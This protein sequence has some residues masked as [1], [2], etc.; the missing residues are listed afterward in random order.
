MVHEEEDAIL[1]LMRKLSSTSRILVQCKMR[2]TGLFLAF[3][4][5]PF[6][7]WSLDLSLLHSCLKYP[8][9]STRPFA[10]DIFTSRTLPDMNMLATFSSLRGTVS[11]NRIYFHFMRCRCET[12]FLLVT[13]DWA[14]FHQ[15]NCEAICLKNNLNNDKNY[16]FLALRLV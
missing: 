10:H 15:Q 5:L 3:A 11:K 4:H 12:Y 2:L 8:V 16:N 1:L 6:Y 14:N 7:F 9:P 13:L